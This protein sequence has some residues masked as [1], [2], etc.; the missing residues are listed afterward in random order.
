MTQTR[1]LLLIAW[2]FVAGWLWLKWAEWTTVP[3]NPA[4]VAT[5]QDGVPTPASPAALP[6]VSQAGAP[7]QAALPSA[8]AA[9]P[10]TATPTTAAA[11]SAPI[12]RLRNDVLEL[13]IDA[14]GD[15]VGSR[16]L[17][18]RE[19]KHTDS[20]PVRLLASGNGT[21]FTAASNLIAVDAQ[22]QR[23]LAPDFRPTDNRVDHAIASGA[24]AVRAPLAWTD[25][26]SGLRIERTL[27]LPRGSYLLTI[28]DRVTNAGTRPQRLF[29]SVELA[30]SAPPEPSRW[31]GFT[32]PET[33]SFVGAAW[34][35]PEDKFNK[36]PFADYDDE[37][38][39]DRDVKG[40]WIGMLQH[41]FVAAWVPAANETQKFSLVQDSAGG[42]PLFRIRS[43]GFPL[44]VAPGTTMPHAT[45]LWVGPKLQKPL[46]AIAPG[47]KYSLDYGMFT[48]IAQPLFDYVLRPL[49][50]LTSNW[51]W[52]IIL[53][54]LLLKLAL[55]PLSA[56]QFRSMAKLRAVQPRIEA[57]KERFGEDR[58]GFQMAMM[59]LY[60]KEKINPI[61]GCLPILIPLPIFF[62]LYW[63][64]L[65][66]VELRHAP[67][68]G[69]IDNLTAPDPYFI[70]P[71]LNLGVMYLTQKMTPTP[72]MD[73]VQ[74][75]MMTAMPLVF[76][77][78]M[79]F[80]PSGLVLYWVTNGLLGLLQQ[81][82]ITRQHGA[83]KA[84]VAR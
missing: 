2:L 78:L 82:W 70:L 14:R 58:Q 35:T 76:G 25:A 66:T 31:A 79:A 13:E 44:D 50:Y 1:S 27:V 59:D 29:P 11:P 9:L 34:Y 17:A 69:W 51:G 64:L 74:K 37:T 18:Y 30:R 53:T 33:F 68:M 41:H 84:V 23:T 55:Y 71:A 62:A 47:L 45:R 72:G 39:P 54:V 61:G 4:T 36:T 3:T 49:H 7:G 60:K 32:S 42:K 80:F 40:G 73:P 63:V 16:L 48:F 46:D 57:L 67:W 19:E 83:G 56:A 20:P 81:W 12:V 15:I 77:V 5:V 75:K 21:R 65:E 28:E 10:G 26:A 22:G 38:P 24:D 6:D 43:V 52:A 8:P